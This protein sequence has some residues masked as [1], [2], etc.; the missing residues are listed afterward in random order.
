[1]GRLVDPSSSDSD[2]ELIPQVKKVVKPVVDKR[3]ILTSQDLQDK[4]WDI[5]IYKKVRVNNYKD[6]LYVDFR[7]Y[8]YDNNGKACP[9][10]KGIQIP[11][12]DL[13]IL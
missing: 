8:F 10:K 12:S 5:G 2:E 4:T 9:T 7:E 3:P 13:P 11:L 6:K 1:M